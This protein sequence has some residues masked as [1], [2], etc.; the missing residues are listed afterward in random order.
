M[1]SLTGSQLTAHSSQ[2]TAHSSQLTAHS[3]QL[4]AHIL[5]GNPNRVNYPI[6]IV[7]FFIIQTKRY[8]SHSLQ[9]LPAYAVTHLNFVGGTVKP[10]EASNEA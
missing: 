3:S 5:F 9:V 4:T 2:L 7:L 6:G 10:Q 1:L 8:F